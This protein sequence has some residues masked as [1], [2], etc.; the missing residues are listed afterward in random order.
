[1]L[2][3]NSIIPCQCPLIRFSIFWMNQILGRFTWKN[4]R[5]W[6]SSSSLFLNQLEL[7]NTNQDSIRRA[8]DLAGLYWEDEHNQRRHWIL[9]P[10]FGGVFPGVLSTFSKDNLHIPRLEIFFFKCF[11]FRQF[12]KRALYFIDSFWDPTKSCLQKQKV[13][14]S[15]Y[16]VATLQISVVQINAK[17]DYY[18]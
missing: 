7:R 4:F 14:R 18:I 15:A 1:M 6:G 3:Y 12:G 5:L 8:S 9:R 10:P 16:R 2:R 13:F 17:I 11:I